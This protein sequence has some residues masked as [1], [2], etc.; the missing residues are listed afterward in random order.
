MQSQAHRKHVVASGVLHRLHRR[1]GGGARG[2][3]DDDLTER[4]L[5]VEGPPPPLPF[6]TIGSRRDIND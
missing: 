6:D 2:A 4:L 1:D 3:P 5:G